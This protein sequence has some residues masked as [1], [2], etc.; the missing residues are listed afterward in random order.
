MHINFTHAAKAFLPEIE[1]YQNFFEQHGITTSISP[2]PGF[3]DSNATVD[4]YFMGKYI[5]KHSRVITV[6]EYASASIPPF[7]RLKDLFKKMMNSKPDFRIFNNEYVQERFAFKDGV[8][9]GIRNFGVDNIYTPSPLLIKKYDFIY[10]GTVGDERKLQPLLQCFVHGPLKER[11][12]LIV[13]R[14]YDQLSKTLKHAPNIHFAGP[15]PHPEVIHFLHQARFG[16]NYI[17]DVAPFNR[18]TSAK[19]IEYSAAQLPVITNT[20]AW[21]E[22]FQK[23]YGGKFFKMEN[24]FSNFTWE[25]ICGFDYHFPNLDEWVWEKQINKSGILPFLL[26]AVVRVM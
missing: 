6:H 10:I 12:L 8:P 20:Y 17:P 19:L 26:S 2:F 3:Y 14:E 16:I 1:A 22:E 11:S 9:S 23:K 21:V 18:Q 4:W 5:K 24:D 7:G 13:S 15:V 25:N